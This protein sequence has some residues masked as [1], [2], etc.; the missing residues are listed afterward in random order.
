[1]LTLLT[2]NFASEN[3]SAAIKAD[4]RG[5][6]TQVDKIFNRE[7]RS[8]YESLNRF[9]PMIEPMIAWLVETGRPN[10]VIQ[11]TVNPAARAAIN[12]PPR[13]FT[14]PSLPN[15]REVP[16][17][18]NFCPK[19]YKNTANKRGSSKTYHTTADCCPENVGGIICTK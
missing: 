9:H 4:S 18:L 11:Y 17:P 19:N 3:N 5:Q 14:A 13:A 7:E 6:T 8:V 12:E 10:F 15:V 1:M 16:V 2:K